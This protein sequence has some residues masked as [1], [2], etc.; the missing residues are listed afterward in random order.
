MVIQ[1][2]EKE[3]SRPESPINR[4][5]DR[6]KEELRP[7]VDGCEKILNVLNR[8]LE[9]YNALSEKERSLRKIW[10]RIRFGNGEL[11]DMNELR[12]KLTYYASALSLFLIM[13]SLGSIGRVEHQME[14]AGGDI[15]KIRIA[16][17]RI[18]ASLL[19]SSNCEGT[20]LTAY[21]D[22]DTA[23]WKEFR[24]EL[25]EEGFSS[26]IIKKHKALIKAYIKELGDRG[27]L[28]DEGPQDIEESSTTT[29]HNVAPTPEDISPADSHSE[30]VPSA[31]LEAVSD[32]FRITLPVY[33]L[34]LWENDPL[35]VLPADCLT[36]GKI[37][38]PIFASCGARVLIARFRARLQILLECL[39]QVWIFRAKEDIDQID[40]YISK[41]EDIEIDHIIVGDFTKSAFQ[42]LA[43][44]V[45]S[46]C[47]DELWILWSD[48]LEAG[49]QRDSRSQR[50][51]CT[52]IE[53]LISS[54]WPFVKVSGMHALGNWIRRFDV[55]ASS[56]VNRLTARWTKAAEMLVKSDCR[57]MT[58]LAFIFANDE[59]LSESRAESQ[60]VLQANDA[61]LQTIW[62]DNY[63]S[64]ILPQCQNFM[65]SPP[66]DAKS[67]YF[68][69]K[70][71]S[72]QILSQ[73][74]MQLDAVD[75]RGNE[76]LRRQRKKLISQ[77]Q[78]M[79]FKLDTAKEFFSVSY[80]D[81]Q[82]LKRRGCRSSSTN[83]P[84]RKDKGP[85]ASVGN[86]ESA[87]DMRPASSR[88]PDIPR[89]TLSTESVDCSRCFGIHSKTSSTEAVDGHQ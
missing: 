5:D 3:I 30:V 38:G 20:V 25:I 46:T 47:A 42:I 24:K 62:Q 69:H 51:I 13:V 14:T 84:K 63:I 26:S 66:S 86:E 15:R 72:E 32:R 85:A 88:Y 41:T 81:W 10:Q 58:S 78:G 27:L 34:D 75:S 2:L 11:A 16:V 40:I 36:V 57:G 82:W 60:E 50:A 76:A 49:F 1:R 17:N 74:I 29:E 7:L 61:A 23:V 68:K 12:E 55:Q 67:R 28:D 73:V 80:E 48:S 89:R 52:R 43:D 18:T 33:D 65:S 54:E 35:T 87:A 59:S 19:S 31:K 53:D 56:V 71:L 21:A 64:E 22:D 77:A 37:D 9:K 45:D 6:C 70:G 79:L 83:P 8:V 4:P 39:P 44:F